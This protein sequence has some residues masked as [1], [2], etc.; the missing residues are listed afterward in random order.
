MNE[1]GVTKVEGYVFV[2]KLKA[3]V[4][5]AGVESV[6]AINDTP[7]L[8]RKNWSSMQ[9]VF[10]IHSYKIQKG[11]KPQKCYDL[12]ENQ[13]GGYEKF[14]RNVYKVKSKDFRIFT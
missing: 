6:M 4:G 3:L 2:V 8:S 13:L 11:R 14:K 5:Y 10:N 1:D 7:P 9:R 12:R